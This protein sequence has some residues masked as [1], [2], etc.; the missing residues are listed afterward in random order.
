MSSDPPKKMTRPRRRALW[1]LLGVLGILSSWIAFQLVSPFFMGPTQVRI[2]RETTY[3]TSPIGPNGLPDFAAA[4]AELRGPSL[5]LGD[6]YSIALMRASNVPEQYSVALEVKQALEFLEKLSR[7]PLG[8]RISE[9]LN[10]RFETELSHLLR[11]EEGTWTAAKNPALSRELDNYE[12]ALDLLVDA[13]HR[14]CA[15][16]PQHSL[17]SLTVIYDSSVTQAARMLRARGLRCAGSGQLAETLAHFEALVT[18]ADFHSEV[19]GGQLFDRY[20]D[21][22]MQVCLFLGRALS[23]QSG[24]WPEHGL[25]VALRHSTR[26]ADHKPLRAH[27]EERLLALSKIVSSAE[28][29]PRF[30][31]DAPWLIRQDKYLDTNLLLVRMNQRFDDLERPIRSQDH[32]GSVK[33]IQEV[34]DRWSKAVQE[35][36]SVDDWNWFHLLTTGPHQ[37]RRIRTQAVAD[38]WKNSSWYALAHARATCDWKWKLKA[39]QSVIAAALALEIHKT[40]HGAYPERLEALAP[41]ILSEVPDDPFTNGPVTYRRIE[42]GFLVYS[43]G[44]DNHDDNGDPEYDITVRVNRTPEA[45]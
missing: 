24:S 43:I 9:R 21:T 14:C 27:K 32:S 31:P 34:Q 38:R 3:I 11:L 1:A 40:K 28:T 42:G 2:S 26:L 45:R 6:R 33:A 35:N 17:S 15:S 12:E 29:L 5:A 16:H 39:Y 44:S 23:G 18:L 10:L 25:R 13:R 22:L 4:L 20:E 41:A 30:M 7:P 19:A 36:H 8:K 37:R